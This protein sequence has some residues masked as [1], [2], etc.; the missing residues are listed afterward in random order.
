MNAQ[1]VT[2]DNFKIEGEN[3]LFFDGSQWIVVC[4]SNW[5]TFTGETAQ[6]VLDNDALVIVKREDGSFYFKSDYVWNR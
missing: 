2:Q 3:C 5:S 1:K 6:D 4:G